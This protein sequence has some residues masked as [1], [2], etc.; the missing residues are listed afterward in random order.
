[1]FLD[2]FPDLLDSFKSLPGQ[3]S[4]LGDFNIHC[5]RPHDTLT[6]NTLDTFNMYNLQQTVA[7][8]TYK[9]GHMLDWVIR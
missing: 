2:Q 9:Q 8:S 1:M 6:A 7:Q 3:L 5:I 4:I